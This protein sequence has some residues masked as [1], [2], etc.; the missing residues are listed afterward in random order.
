MKKLFYTQFS[1]S[2]FWNRSLAALTFF[3]CLHSQLSSIHSVVTIKEYGSLCKVI[4]QIDRKCTVAPFSNFTAKFE[5]VFVLQ[6]FVLSFHF[7]ANR[8]SICSSTKR[9]R[10]FQNSPPFEKPACFY[11]K[12]WAFCLVLKQIFW[13][14]KTFFKKLE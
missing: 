14:M 3:M 2:I 10:D 13:K 7:K 6:L 11:V 5:L 1:T 4:H 12:Y 8:E 9:Y